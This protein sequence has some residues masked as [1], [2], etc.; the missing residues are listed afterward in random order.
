M[1]LW[2]T[3][4]KQ[5]QLRNLMRKRSSDRTWQRR[6]KIQCPLRRG[7]PAQGDLVEGGTLPEH[8]PERSLVEPVGHFQV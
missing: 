4:Q 2:G 6:G 7:S 3:S 5:C 1:E 8:R